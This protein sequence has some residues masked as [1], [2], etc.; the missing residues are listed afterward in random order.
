MNITRVGTVALIVGLILLMNAWSEHV[1]GN[2]IYGAVKVNVTETNGYVMY[3]PPVGV[4]NLTVGFHRYPESTY[5]SPPG[6]V[7]NVVVPV[8]MKVD[9][10][11]NQTI[12]EQDLVTPQ[13]FE[14]TFTT[15]G[16]YTVYLTNNGN[17]TVHIPIGLRFKQGNPANREADKYLLSILLIALGAVIVVVGF[18]L[19]FFKV[20]KTKPTRKV[21]PEAKP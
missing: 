4:G 14:V 13:S 1:A 9:D 16:L 5:P 8:H 20:Q 18:V 3:M 7:D 12:F 11:A 19:N 2:I 21:L 10:P 15:R 17:E 6:F